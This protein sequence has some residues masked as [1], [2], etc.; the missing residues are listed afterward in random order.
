MSNCITNNHSK[1]NHIT[2]NQLEYVKEDKPQ[3][4]ISLY[5]L[6]LK[7]IF[8]KCHL[9]KWVRQVKRVLYDGH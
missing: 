2:N 4:L 6:S 9:I 7:G 3:Q 8:V 5:T 1:L